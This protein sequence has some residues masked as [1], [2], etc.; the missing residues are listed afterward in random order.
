MDFKQLCSFV[1]VVK[2]NSFTKAAEN[3]YLSQ[4]TISTHIRQLEAELGVELIHRTTKHTEI[5]EKGREIYEYAIH[6][7]NIRDRML[8]AAAEESQKVLHLGASTIP[9]AYI[10]PEL[11]SAYGK[12]HP[13]CYFV[14][15]QDDS[16]GVERGIVDGVFDIGLI[17]M[18]AE[19]PS[20]TCLPFCE[21]RMVLITPVEE[22]Y[23]SLC[24]KKETP[25]AD[26]LTHPMILREAG[27]GTRKSAD[28]FLEAA[29][30]RED[31]LRIAARIND[32]EA[33]KNLVAKGLGIS[34]ISAR[35]ADNFV[36]AKRLLAFSLDQYAKPRSLYIVFQKE[37]DLSKELK[38]FIEFAKRFC[39]SFA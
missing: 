3:L 20:L 25:L 5:T 28:R 18:A 37:K 6:M 22:P 33:I 35:A 21:D 19:D 17:G 9:S 16:A 12:D 34:V 1:E 31:D 13:D 23:L 11:L 26:L 14:I 15:H 30:V 27:S 24:R 4:P 32:P 2:E 38:V 39:A 10:L 29:G 36:K 8:S 7:L